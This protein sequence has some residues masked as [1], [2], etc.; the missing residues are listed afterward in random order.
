G[1]HGWQLPPPSDR[2]H[3]SRVRRRPARPRLVPGAGLRP[4][5][6][7]VLLGEEA[8]V[9]GVVPEGASG[10]VDGE[11]ADGFAVA[12]GIE[13]VI[14]GELA[15]RAAAGIACDLLAGARFCEP[16]VSDLDGLGGAGD[17]AGAGAVPAVPAAA[18]HPPTH[19]RAD[20]AA[21][22]AHRA[23]PGVP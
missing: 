15:R 14:A 8:S 19:H 4:R 12:G 10:G 20:V 7:E 13:G 6:S 21:E 11:H 22:A 1:S 18:H 3:G 9:P 17:L 2:F 16:T 23:V 5:A